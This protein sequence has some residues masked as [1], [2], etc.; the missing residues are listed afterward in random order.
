MSTYILPLVG[1][2][3]K[4]SD[5]ATRARVPVTTVSTIREYILATQDGT[6]HI[7]AVSSRDLMIMARHAQT[8]LTEMPTVVISAPGLIY[9][10][11]WL[12]HAT[13]FPAVDWTEL[14]A[15]MLKSGTLSHTPEQLEDVT[16]SR[17]TGYR[18]EVIENFDEEDV[19]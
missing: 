13:A 3:D 14:E 6:M 2:F 18:D 10:G 5:L 11:S 7:V 19:E 9:E 4:I 1:E 12:T 15:K 8:L 16:R 17:G